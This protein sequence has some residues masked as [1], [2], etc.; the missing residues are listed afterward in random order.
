MTEKEIKTEKAGV[1]GGDKVS[2]SLINDAMGAY[3]R[4]TA[5]YKEKYVH[6]P[7]KQGKAFIEDRKKKI[8]TGAKDLVEKGAQLK[9]RLPVVKKIEEGIR[10]GVSTLPGRLNL[11]SRKDIDN[12]A[13]ALENLSKKV[14]TLD[15]NYSV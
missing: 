9:D 8:V 15:R 2:S 14:D 13:G 12:L 3:R 1:E 11:P 7:M 6:A 10:N 4:V 5:A